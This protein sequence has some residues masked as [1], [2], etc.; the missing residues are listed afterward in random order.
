MKTFL[1]ILTYLRDYRVRLI[2]AFICSAGVAG[3]SAVYAWLVQPVLDEIFIDRN[4]ELLLLLPLAVLGVAIL[5]GAFAYGQGY[6]MSYIGH[7][8]VADVRQ[9][10]FMHIVRLPIRFH[11]AN[12]SGRLVAR[13]ISDVNEMANAIPSVLKD[14]FQQGLTFVALLGVAFYQNWKL[15]SIVIVVLPFSGLVLMRVGKRI[16]KLSKRGQESI[17]RMASV[18]KEAF[19]GIK[20]VKAYGQEGKELERFSLTNAAYR[21]AKV[22]SSQTSAMA[23]PL[24][25]V[26]GV[27]GVIVIIWFGGGLVID[28]GMKPGEFFSFLT[29]MFMAYAPIR[30][31]S[32]ANES[33]QRALAG[34]QRVFSVLD[35]DSELAKDEGKATLQPITHTLEFAN[36]TFFY[37]EAN[38]P[39]LKNLD[40]VIRAGEVVA[41]VGASGSGKSTLVSLV[42]RFYRPAEGTVR[43]D[44]VDIRTVDRASL[45][46]QI[47]IV[48][49]ETVL[50]DDSIRNNIAYGRPDASEDAII[51]ASQAAFAWEFIDRLPNGLK[52]LIG[53]NGLKLSGGQRQRLAIARAILRD[54]P[55][56]IL[57]EATSALDSESEKLV[58][59]ALANLMK[60]RTTLVIAH[61]LSTVQHADRIVVMAKGTIQETGTHGELL[62]RGGLYTKLYHTQ[63][64]LAQFEP[65]PTP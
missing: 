37:E 52:T 7:W 24:L 6:L 27:C 2:G 57:D 46:R 25:E 1:R 5:K 3:L 53:E 31:M 49:Q 60:G 42:P 4:R 50:F 47:G 19:S 12:S 41:F 36:V 11:D 61:R 26:I 10:L 9:Q 40:L 13:V 16:R 33:V 63:F 56:L 29:A 54:P 21:S 48:S 15:A 58:Q 17:G 64:Q 38:E 51:A 23:S 44:G 32:G 55:I 20:I 39:A 34:A 65:I 14:I 35:L 30:K 43:I 22:K 59:Q 45:R 62:Q 28:G 18:L 8:L